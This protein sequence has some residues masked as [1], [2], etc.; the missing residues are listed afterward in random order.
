MFEM[1]GLTGFLLGDQ[2]KVKYSMISI[3]TKMVAAQADPAGVT[4]LQICF[5]IFGLAAPIAFTALAIALWLAPMK[6]ERLG[7][8]HY[9]AEILYAWAAL[10]VF[11]VSIAAALLEIGQFASFAVGRKCNDLNALLAEAFDGPL[12][13]HGNDKCFDVSAHLLPVRLLTT[14]SIACSIWPI[15]LKLIVFFP[16]LPLRQSISL[17]LNNSTLLLLLLLL[18]GCTIAELVVV[19]LICSLAAPIGPTNR[20]SERRK[21]HYS[22]PSLYPEY[23]HYYYHF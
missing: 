8:L 15:A 9:S 7:W 13:L 1:S 14:Y 21:A 3:G 6:K 5:Y 12:Q 19:V 2:A 4:F 18:A 11:C 23:G 17:H 10:D 16:C 22:L 20:V